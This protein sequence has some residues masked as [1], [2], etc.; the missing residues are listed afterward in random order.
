MSASATAEQASATGQTWQAANIEYLHAEF[1]RLR[2]LLQRRVLWLRRMW[3]R[4]LAQQFQ[5][6]PGVV[7]TDSDADRLLHPATAQSE[8]RFYEQDES[9]QAVTRAL[10]EQLIRVQR[11]AQDTM[12][13]GGPPALAILCR[14]FQLGQFERD[15]LL[16]CLAPS[17]DAAFER[18]YGYVQDD[19]A[20]KYATAGL[21]MQ[22]LVSPDEGSEV[23]ASLWRHLSPDAPLLRFG[24]LLADSTPGANRASD[25]LRLNRRIADYLLGINHLDEQ[26]TPVVRRV[27]NQGA[28]GDDQEA[29]VEPLERRLRTWN[30]WEHMPLIQLTGSSAAAHKAIASELCARC[31]VSL[32]AV[33]LPRLLAL[34]A[35]RQNYYR[36]L[37]R[38]SLLLPC[39]YYLDLSE[40]DPANR[41]EAANVIEYLNQV[42]T[43]AIVAGREPLQCE[44]RAIAVRI[45][46]SEATAQTSVWNAD[47]AA[48]LKESGARNGSGVT[49]AFIERLV[50]QFHFSPQQIHRV[51]REAHEAASLRSPEAPV[52]E[53]ADLWFTARAQATRTMDGLAERIEA[54]RSL[55]ELV[56][57]AEQL[58]Q[59]REIAS[60]VEHRARVYEEWGFGTKL[61]RG[62]GIAALFAGPSGTGK[63]MAAE[64]LANHLDLDLYRIDIASV[65][66]KY[67][68]EVEKNLRRV[69]DAA[70]ESGAILF[71]DEADS[72]FG[73]RSEV[74]D[75]HDRYA[76]I[77]INYLL[78]R[79]EDYRGLAIL[80]TNRKSLLDQ[81]FLRR[82]RFL[83]DFPFP[84]AADR[85]RIWQGAFPAQA[86]KESLD[87][88]FLGRL[89]IAGGSICNIALSA[90]FLAAS[91][92]MRIHMHH[93]LT[94]ARREYAKID[95][96]MVEGEFERYVAPAPRQGQS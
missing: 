11:E 17:V 1:S 76:N 33:D 72:L 7:I 30:D 20:Q 45:S 73:K 55:D 93:V 15:V 31:G 56:L 91:Q 23:R 95:K 85:V 66:S 6:F 53:A 29:I 71:F 60:Q 84:S 94:A 36:I 89:D 3:K 9:A 74:R 22:T 2:L 90:A 54:R 61:N 32:Y 96:L 49:G 47:L 64:V 51:V 39:A 46:R 35:D 80:A 19:A 63:T 52:L 62:K 41:G 57:P 34:G 13:A 86:E 26:V 65:M 92:G 77:E 43:F 25:L 16:L 69:F 48:Y 37:E 50:Q 79:M 88:D 70:E 28:L 82:L 81:A 40:A 18:L 78:Q 83:V 8:S 5:N 27:H 24:L 21:A 10:E 58:S 4:D 42:H 14:L 67:I 87:Y 12:T 75:S 59:I 44:R 38:E 68:G